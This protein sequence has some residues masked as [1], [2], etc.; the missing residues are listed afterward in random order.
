MNIA[1]RKPFD[2]MA[3]S[4]F[5]SLLALAAGSFAQS[6]TSF[7]DPMTDIT[8]QA[9]T[10][11]TTG[12]R[13]GIALPENPTTDFIAQL[14][15]PLA[16]SSGW[17]GADLGADMVNQLLIVA[18]PSGNRV[19]S[20][21]REASAYANPPV[22][23]GNHSLSMIP[24]AKGTAVTKTDFTYTFLCRGCI[25]NDILSFSP[26][27][28]GTVF[29]WAF[30]NTAVAS[31][32]SPSSVLNFHSAGYGDYGVQLS[33]AKSAN[34]AQWAAL[35]LNSTSTGAGSGAGSSTG[36]SSVLRG[37]AIPSAS[38]SSG[39]KGSCNKKP[40]QG[41]TGSVST[42]PSPA[43]NAESSQPEAAAPS[44]AASQTAPSAASGSSGAGTGAGLF[45]HHRHHH[46]HHNGSFPGSSG[47]LFGGVGVDRP[48]HFHVGGGAARRAASLKQ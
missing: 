28:S 26:T 34:Y 10:D 29:G 32:S 9:F 39:S 46:H 3:R 21:F 12:Y 43:N 37:S 4:T 25:T 1:S 48:R 13:F 5:F 18:Y 44:S 15:A 17:V 16:N 11:P 38:S 47:T 22:Y 27:E 33:K 6:T 30:S 42:T 36:P 31:P 2:T 20:S 40:G 23:R 14:H 8:F 35:A 45:P 19:V 7:V 41:Q 24:I